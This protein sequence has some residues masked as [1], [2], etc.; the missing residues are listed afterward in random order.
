MK[1]DLA[2]YALIALMLLLICTTVAGVAMWLY[3][4]V[5]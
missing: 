2:D 3:E 5:G 4:A 1:R